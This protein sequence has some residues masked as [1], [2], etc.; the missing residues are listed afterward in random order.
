V[1]ARDRSG[2][3]PVSWVLT[4]RLHVRRTPYVGALAAVTAGL[5]TSYLAWS[6]AGAAL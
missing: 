1:A 6:G 3:V 4:D 5:I 2:R